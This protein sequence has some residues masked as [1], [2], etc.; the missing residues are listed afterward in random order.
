MLPQGICGKGSALQLS[1]H[2][3]EN[4]LRFE[5]NGPLLQQNGIIR[6]FL[7]ASFCFITPAI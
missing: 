2:N 6:G 3:Y 7:T 5:I 4:D 1:T